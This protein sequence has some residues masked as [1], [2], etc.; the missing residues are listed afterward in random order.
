ML[1]GDSTLTSTATFGGAVTSGYITEF[2]VAPE[3]AA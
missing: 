1:T 2:T 3:P